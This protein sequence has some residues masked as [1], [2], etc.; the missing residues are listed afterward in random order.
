MPSKRPLKVGIIL[1][2]MEEWLG[3]KTP[4]WSDMKSF[5]QHVEAAGFDSLWVNDHLLFRIEGPD[6]P[7]RGIW[8]GWTPMS[9]LAAPPPASNS[10]PSCSAPAFVTPR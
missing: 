5:A 9:A 8:D 1:P 10:E 6:S 2:T 3:G 7:T 4:R